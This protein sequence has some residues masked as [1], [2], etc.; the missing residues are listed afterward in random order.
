MARC[1]D[2][3]SNVVATTREGLR[4]TLR[5]DRFLVATARTLGLILVTSDARLLV[6]KVVAT[7]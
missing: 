4:Q 5:A 7:L 2:I 1:H 6:S 3:K